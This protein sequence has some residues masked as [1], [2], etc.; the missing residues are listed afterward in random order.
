MLFGMNQAWNR[1]QKEVTI[2][3]TEQSRIPY[4]WEQAQPVPGSQGSSS[5]CALQHLLQRALQLT[6]LSRLN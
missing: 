4:V 2:Q 6:E 5:R 3:L 1:A